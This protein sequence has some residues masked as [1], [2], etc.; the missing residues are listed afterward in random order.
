MQKG[1]WS[2]GMAKHRTMGNS[3]TCDHF[4]GPRSPGKKTRRNS[5]TRKEKARNHGKHF[6]KYK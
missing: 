2:L 5:L 3:H 1:T 4:T 6:N